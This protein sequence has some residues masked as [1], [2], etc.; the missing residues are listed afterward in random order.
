MITLAYYSGARKGEMLS[1]KW[2]QVDLIESKTTLEAGTTKNDEARVIYMDG[3]L[4]ESIS[5]Q[6]GLRGKSFPECPYVFL[7]IRENL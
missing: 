1:L 7:M 2:S 6:R 4:Y 3:G 5:F